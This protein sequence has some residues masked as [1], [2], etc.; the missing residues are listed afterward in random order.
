MYHHHIEV[1]QSFEIYREEATGKLK[2]ITT[3]MT[4]III[5]LCSGDKTK[6][7]EN[8]LEAGVKEYA[9]HGLRNLAVAYKE[10]N[11]E[12]HEAEGNGFE[13]IGHL[14][15]LD[16]PVKIPSRPLMIL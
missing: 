14:P 11:I 5:K 15:I 16:P 1:E 3:G 8:E 4:G 13:L 6:E 7:L 10:L 9:I 12:D 2:R